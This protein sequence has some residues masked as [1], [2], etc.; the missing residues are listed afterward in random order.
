MALE[1]IRRD[2]SVA[3]IYGFSGGGYNARAIWQQ[4]SIIERQRLRKMIVVGSPGIDESQFAGQPNILI[5]P[6]P[7]EGHIAGPKTLLES[8]DR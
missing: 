2:G 3:G 4:L 1:R 6:D 5:V 8:L 7:P